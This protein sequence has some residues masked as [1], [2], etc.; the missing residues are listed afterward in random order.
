MF[1]V[2]LSPVYETVRRLRAE[3]PAET[4]LIGFCGAPWTVATYMIAGHGTPDQAPARLFA[5]RHPEAMRK[6]LK[7]LADHS[8]AYLIRQ[9]D[10]G[11]DAVQIFDSWSGVLDESGFAAFCIEPVAE[12]VRQVR[13]AHPDVPI[14][15]F[16]KRRRQPL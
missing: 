9:I 16:P 15:G 8:A 7:L 1:H 13:A 2:N 14:I 6:L 12:I 11:A 3:L 10:A 5:Y 4:T